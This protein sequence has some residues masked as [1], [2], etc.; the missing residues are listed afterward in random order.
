MPDLAPQDTQPSS[1]WADAWEGYELHLEIQGR[2]RSTVSSR[3]SNVLAMARYF[4]A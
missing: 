1:A 3:K 4:T 2:S